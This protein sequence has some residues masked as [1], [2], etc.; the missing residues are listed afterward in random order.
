VG[1]VSCYQPTNSS[2]GH[3]TESNTQRVI[4]LTPIL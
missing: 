1:E 4:D 2:P 3:A